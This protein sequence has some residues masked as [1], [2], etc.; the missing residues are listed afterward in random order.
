GHETSYP[1]I[2]SEFLGLP[3]N[4]FRLVQA[5]TRTVRSGAGHG[6]ARSMHQGGTALVKA[7]QAVIEK[8]R[9]IAA[10]LLQ[11]DP[12]E[13]TFSA[14]SFAVLET[15]REIDLVVVARA[16]ADPAN[17]PDGMAPGLDSYAVNVSDVF[18]FPNGCHIA[19]IEIDIETGAVSIE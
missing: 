18:T 11:A 19:E 1:Q 6:G 14:G 12:A 10:R 16:A 2:A 5:D 15:G 3:L 9:A 17:L 8:G 4:S 7:A 13:I